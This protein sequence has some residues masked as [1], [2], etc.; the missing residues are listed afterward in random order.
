M[1]SRRRVRE[2]LAGFLF[3]SPWLLGFLLYNGG[4]IGASLAISFT[5]WNI[6]QKPTFVGLDNYIELFAQDP[7]FWH[8]LKITSIYSAVVVPLG[9][10]VAFLLALVL[11]ERLKGLV[12]WRTLYYLPSLITGVAM[13]LVWSIILNPDMGL[14]NQVLALFGIPGPR[15]LW[16]SGWALPG[17]ILMALWQTGGNIIIYLAG[18]QGI[19]SELYES[20]EIDGGGMWT[21]F[22]A[23]TVP[24]MTPILFFQLIMGIVHSLQVFEIAFVM[25]RGGPMNSTLFFN[26]LLYFKAFEDFKMG[27]ACSMAWILFVII[28]SLTILIF[29]S[30]ARW[31]YY[32]GE[33]S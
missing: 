23:I 26:L 29:R 8:S 17:L 20:V 1:R 16:D 21:K 9:M 10:A 28:A 12:I 30:S 25:T 5:R 15:W 7:L 6:V 24:M 4:S 18:L 22:R 13:A 3:I 31:V 32:A 27:A 33:R 14:V 19:P 11:N 2:A